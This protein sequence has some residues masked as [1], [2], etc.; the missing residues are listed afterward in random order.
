MAKLQNYRIFYFQ[1]PVIPIL[2]V[3]IPE[4]IGKFPLFIVALG[5]IVSNLYKKLVIIETAI[6]RKCPVLSRWAK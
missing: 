3:N 1:W 2:L 5:K 6:L 4:N